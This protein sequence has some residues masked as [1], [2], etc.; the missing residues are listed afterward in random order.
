MSEFVH[1]T[2]MEGFPMKFAAIAA[3]AA[4][5]ATPILADGL[6]DDDDC[7]HTAKRRAVTPSAGITKV[8]IH[9]ESG[10]LDVTGTSGATQIIA[11]GTACSSD[12]DFIPRM[13]LTLRKSGS[14]LHI[15]TEIPEKTIIFGF[16]SARL[17]FAVTLPAGLP[18]EIEDGSGWLKV[19]NTGATNIDDGSG[20]I[21]V[22]NVRGPL[23][24]HDGS[25]SIEI[26]TVAGN[27]TVEDQSGELS[28]KNVTGSVEIEDSSGAISVARVEGSL[29]IRDDG[30]GSIVVQNVRRDVTIDEDGSGAVDVADVGGNF[31]VG[32]KGSGHI[33]YDRVAGR[34]T[35]PSRD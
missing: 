26:D 3:V 22:R 18:I 14:E 4:L 6:F 1:V 21:E 20:S 12:E 19:A 27:V 30:S 11:D 34:V 7:R 8:V 35:V 24:I 23:V 33:D 17:D 2:E 5:V 10:S 9:A 13:T 15:D 25:G 29:R 28:V 32:R 31:T 16:F